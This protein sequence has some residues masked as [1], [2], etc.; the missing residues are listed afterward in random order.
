MSLGD[1]QLVKN[2]QNG[3]HLA[4]SELVTR[5]HKKYYR[6][7]YRY[8]YNKNDA[9]DVVQE[10]FLKLWENP[11]KW[12]LITG[13]KF[14][15]WFYRIIINL[16]FD[17]NKK[18]SELNTD[19]LDYLEIRINETNDSN[20]NSNGNEYTETVIKQEKRDEVIKAI[21][22]LPK[23]QQTALN[24]CFYE[25]VSHKEAAKIMKTTTSAVRSLLMRAKQ[26]LYKMLK[27]K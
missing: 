25:Q 14:T 20:S 2:I 3:D 15:T 22:S 9:E 23:R 16:A 10:A 6:V 12:Q 1:E 27:D 26:N 19:N 21:K 13:V 17:K 8:L 5:H 7:A 24:L 4:F 11:Y 18:K